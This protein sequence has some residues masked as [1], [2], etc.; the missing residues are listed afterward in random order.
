MIGSWL[1]SK[2]C[3][4]SVKCA[5][6][7]E[8]RTCSEA[9]VEMLTAVVGTLDK[10]AHEQEDQHVEQQPSQSSPGSPRFVRHPAVDDLDDKIHA[11]S[12]ELLHAALLAACAEG[13]GN[14]RVVVSRGGKVFVEIDLPKR[15]LDDRINCFLSVICLLYTSPSPRDRTRSR[16]PSSA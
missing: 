12:I 2:E 4:I 3:I 11:C 1:Q 10:D 9:I 6:S 15:E 13:D 5:L 7:S 14:G 8:T 16:M